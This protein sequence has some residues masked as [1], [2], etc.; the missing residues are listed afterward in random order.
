M[1]RKLEFS[2]FKERII[3]TFNNGI[4][5]D[6]F[7]YVNNNTKGLCKCNKCGNE[8][9]AVPNSLLNGHGCRKCYDKKNSDKRKISY[10]EIV[11]TLETNGSN[12]E[13][14]GDYIDTKHICKIKC[15]LCG[16][17]WEA[18]ITKH[19]KG[20]GCPVCK[21]GRM[22][23]DILIKKLENIYGDKYVY[24]KV[25]YINNRTKIILTCKKH[26]DFTILPSTALK[27]FKERCA[28]C[29]DEEKKEKEILLNKI[30]EEKTA[31]KCEKNKIK[32]EKKRFKQSEKDKIEEFILKCKKVHYNEPY[33]YSLTKYINSK[34]K[35]KVNC[36]KH[37]IFEKNPISLLN[38]QKCPLCARTGHKYTNEEWIKLAKEKYPQFDYSKVNYINKETKVIVVCNNKD[39]DGKIHGEFS[40]YPNAFLRGENKCVKCIKE[41]KRI[42]KQNDFILKSQILNNNKYDYSKVSY[43]GANTKVCII[44]PDHGEF[45]QTPTN[46]LHGCK[47]PKCAI[48]NNRMMYDIKKREFYGTF[49]ERAKKIHNDKYSY[50]KVIYNGNENKVIITCPEHGDFEQTPHS[51]LAGGGCPKCAKNKMVE[52]IRL[53]QEEYINRVRY[54]HRY[55]NYDFTKVLY[56]TY[57]S[58]VTV[59]CLKHGDFI[60][61]AGSLLNGHGCPVCRLSKL[62]ISVRNVL[63]ENKIKHESQKRFKEW[64]GSQSL[65]FYIEGLNIAIECQGMQ[66]FK[67][68]RRYQKLNE[69]QERDERKK[70]LCKE[71]GVHLIYYVPDIFA[72]YMKEDDIFF[73]NTNDLINYIKE[74][75]N[76]L[77]K[78]K[79]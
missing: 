6:N 70:R 9:Y 31:F 4:N 50:D 53:T 20:S 1:P 2:E 15:K 42:Q 48:D 59:T 10:D 44:C 26:G 66:H 24:N 69:I 18:R 72:E 52:A 13:I 5:V 7:I 76:N 43:N 17:E 38:G 46:H 32:K 8:W 51:H 57:E 35:V 11:H 58:D 47:C 22:T 30:K 36:L 29:I 16:R 64:L 63:I 34:T 3:K 14:I 33:D 61:K 68:E 23:T 65:D 54:V 25:E 75:K 67:N 56:N 39:C 71:N 21:H 49:I 37:G 77:I 79:I 78:Y 27:G 41:E 28:I 12:V 62:E 19:L 55:N 45:W 73:T 60:I 74:Y 40:V